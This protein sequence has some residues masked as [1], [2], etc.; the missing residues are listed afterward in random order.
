MRHLEFKTIGGNVKTSS[1]Q[2]SFW[3]V[4]FFLGR[5]AKYCENLR[6][7][8]YLPA[9]EI[10]LQCSEPPQLVKIL[11]SKSAVLLKVPNLELIKEQSSP[12]IPVNEFKKVQQRP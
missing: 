10:V 5:N 3:R 12:F 4:W 2:E 9:E 6:M 7:K 8:D 1:G 11:P